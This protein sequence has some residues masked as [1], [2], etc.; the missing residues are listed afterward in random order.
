[1]AT[2]FRKRG[3]S[4]RK[5]T[6]LANVV[7]FPRGQYRLDEGSKSMESIEY[8]KLDQLL[9]L[10]TTHSPNYMSPLPEAILYPQIRTHQGIF[11]RDRCYTDRGWGSAGFLS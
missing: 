11:S 10:M 6:Y 7:E 9:F 4:I 8:L 2:T 1:M 5:L 3:S